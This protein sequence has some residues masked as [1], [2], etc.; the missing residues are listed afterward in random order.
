MVFH[1]L[2][3][4]WLFS[5]F[6][7]F[8]QISRHTCFDNFKFKTVKFDLQIDKKT[9]NDLYSIKRKWHRNWDPICVQ[10][11]LL[12]MPYT[13]FDYLYTAAFYNKRKLRPFKLFLKNQTYDEADIFINDEMNVIQEFTLAGYGIKIITKQISNL[14]KNVLRK[15]IMKNSL[16]KLNVLTHLR[17]H[18]EGNHS[19]E[20][21]YAL[22][23]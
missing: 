5:R 17:Y 20:K 11:Y 16:K 1:V 8:N 15:K 19:N 2:T 12:S 9:S 23:M 6:K 18:H 22:F 13:G 3:R 4:E 21:L 10:I 7:Y 14:L